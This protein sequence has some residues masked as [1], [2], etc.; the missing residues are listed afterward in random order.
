MR[1]RRPGPGGSEAE[2]GLRRGLQAL[3]G[4]ASA[5]PDALE[6]ILAR[7]TAPTPTPAVATDR[8]RLRLG[9]GAG[10]GVAAAVAAAAAVLA[11]VLAPSPRPTRVV[12]S[13]PTVRALTP[14]AWVAGGRLHVAMPGRTPRTVAAAGQPENP[15]W[16]VDHHWLAYLDADHHQVHV[17][18][19]DG[20]GDRAVGSDGVGRGGYTWSPG[21][22]QLAVVPRSGGVVVVSMPSG[23][24]TT[25][26]AGAV[27]VESVAWSRDGGRLA[28]TT[29]AAPG[30]PAHVVVVTAGGGGSA[31]V[32][33]LALPP[34]SDVLLAGWWPDGTG[35]I[36]WVDPGGSADALDNGLPL[37]S[38]PLAGGPSRLLAV[39]LVFHP[40][41][42]WSPDGTRLLLVAGAGQSPATGK[43]LVVCDTAGTACRPL[44]QPAG[45]VALDAAW[46]PDGT[47]IALVR[48][49]DIGP[50]HHVG[51]AWYAQRRLWVEAPDGSDAFTLAGGGAG[52]AQPVWSADGRSIGYSLGSGFEV[53]PV[54]GGHPT[55]IASGLTGGNDGTAGPDAAGK[56]PWGA[57]AVWGGRAGFESYGG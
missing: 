2:E 48:A 15:E 19:P 36:Y 25:V 21:G 9:V 40:W 46:S 38:A 7:D 6:R 12:S 18:G 56:Q 14:V 27:P 54:S 45:T 29:P 30:R 28:Y 10:V 41:I 43:S 51:P 47:E 32:V 4:R 34:G 17:A 37:L 11:L 50:G 52:V 31:Q 44:P 26:V 39:T 5:S 24:E 55:V 1:W 8:R 33:P 23:L 42:S 20:T 35:L 16:S 57:A 53:I 49:P 22:D 3:A 13:A